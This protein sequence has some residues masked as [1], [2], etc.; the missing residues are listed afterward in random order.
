MNKM[1][2]LP[3]LK[4]ESVSA[5][6]RRKSAAQPT[7]TIIIPL[8]VTH[9]RSDLVDRVCHVFCDPTMPEGV[10]VLVVDDGSHPDHF[11]R[12]E[13]AIKGTPVKLIT[14]GAKYYQTFNPS[15]ARNYGAQ[16]ATGE[17]VLFLDADLVPY[18]GFFKDLYYEI[19]YMAQKGYVN[20]FLMI[21]CIYL[22]DKGYETF[23][24]ISPDERKTR[25]IN[26][27]LEQ[28]EELIQQFSTG[29]SAIVVR[30]DYYLVRGGNDTKFVG[31]GFEDYEFVCRLIRRSRQFP[32]S[33]DWLKSDSNFIKIKRYEGWKAVYRLHG[34]WMARKGIW[35]FHVPHAIEKSLHSNKDRNWRLF[36]ERLKEDAIGNGEPPALPDLSAGRSLALAKNPFTYSREIAPYLGEVVFR[37]SEDFPSTASLRAF[38]KNERITRIV[39]ANPYKDQYTKKIYKWCQINKFPLIICERGALPDSVFYDDTG[40]LTDSTKY[41]RKN[42]DRPL[43]EGETQSVEKYI[44]SIRWGDS[45][46]EKQAKRLDTYKVREKLGI[47]AKRKILLVPFQQPRDTVIRF[48]SGAIESFEK[49]YDLVGSLPEKLGDDWVVVYKKHPTEDDLA[50]IPGAVNADDFNIHDLIE[51][52][53]AMLLINS[54]TGILGMMFGKPVYVV[55]DSWYSDSDIN[56]T[57]TDPQNVTPEKVAR[58][59]LDGFEID[60]ERVLRFIHYL[61][62]EFYSFGA[63][64]QRR[65]RYEDGTPITA[66]TRIDYY[67]VRGF[68]EKPAIY[69]KSFAPIP[70]TSPI[71]DRYD[72]DSLGLAK[73]PHASKPTP[74]KARNSAA[75]SAPVPQVAL[76]AKD[77]RKA[78]LLKLK[79]NPHA[80]FRD[81][82]SPA[83]SKL[84]FIFPRSRPNRPV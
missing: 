45:V 47:S 33:A 48:F 9:A 38:I 3:A 37:T 28:D 41:H 23:S 39:F 81:S 36:L 55:G 64:H 30:R 72:L 11:C 49:F 35:L 52:C 75:R 42:W 61:R 67:E 63:Q 14:T 8:R 21:P 53:D 69:R 56:F 12:L 78:K 80:F 4:T 65:V 58:K 54:G 57:F 20:D 44:S 50:V 84:R 15:R 19:G 2:N 1:N 71:F 7:L 79:Q 43:S 76:S 51:I 31:W 59:I 68:S 5:V 60:Y 25:M 27:M 24:E 34:E 29:T 13:E 16:H 66:T 62:F 82:K 10:S 70:K 77:K 46:L 83:L 6:M 17:Y 73:L 22:T 74:P 32:L 40:F 26:A 18:P